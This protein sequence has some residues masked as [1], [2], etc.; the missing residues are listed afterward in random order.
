MRLF[1]QKNSHMIEN[2][3]LSNIHED[4]YYTFETSWIGLPCFNLKSEELKIPV[5]NLEIENA[6]LISMLGINDH[7][8][9]AEKCYF[10]FRKV[11]R[12]N[13]SLRLHSEDRKSFIRKEEGQSILSK[14]KDSDKVRFEL[15]G[16]GVYKEHTYDGTLQIEAESA[17][18]VVPDINSIRY[19]FKGMNEYTP[20]LNEWL[21]NFCQSG[22]SEIW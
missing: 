2:K 1:L 18:L 4:D 6:S 7:R 14:K 22:E 12:V 10:K 16:M 13:W 8:V 15:A 3:I 20:L 21:I 19:D 11:E 9:Y 5:I 17:Y